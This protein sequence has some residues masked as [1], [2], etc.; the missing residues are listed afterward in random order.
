MSEDTVAN[1]GVVAQIRAA[2]AAHLS[3]RLAEVPADAALGDDLALDSLD[4]FAV[5]D[6]AGTSMGCRLAFD[7][8]DP[9]VV[10][11]LGDM[12]SLTV[13]AFAGCLTCG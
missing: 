10:T 2:I 9:T 4:V 11:R 7:F 12:G 5:L 3:V 1:T 6:R 13:T 8:A